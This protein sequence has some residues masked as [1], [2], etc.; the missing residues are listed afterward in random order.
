MLTISVFRDTLLVE[1]EQIPLII[2][3]Y[4]SVTLCELANLV[5]ITYI[6]FKVICISM[7]CAILSAIP[8]EISEEMVD[9]IQIISSIII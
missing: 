5:Y 4:S 2:V 1:K 6:N 3:R 8:V 9:Q 7:L